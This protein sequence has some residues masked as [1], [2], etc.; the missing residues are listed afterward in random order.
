[1]EIKEAFLK[2]VQQ[3]RIESGGINEETKQDFSHRKMSNSLDQIPPQIKTEDLDT[4]V[5]KEPMTE[6]QPNRARKS[7]RS[8]NV[9][10]K[11]EDLD[12]MVVKEPMTEP[13]PNRARKS[14]RSVNVELKT[15]DLDT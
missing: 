11:T 15:E 13:Q 6:P 3:S 1:M 9:E 10:L 8:V 2:T 14:Q 4:M 7:Q 12:T 5:V